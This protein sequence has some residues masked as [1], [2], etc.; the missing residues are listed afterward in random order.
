MRDVLIITPTRSRPDSAVRLADAVARTATAQTDLLF[1]IDEDDRSYDHLDLTGAAGVVRGPRANCV[2]WS[3]RLAA[4]YGHRYRALASL[5]D[6]HV[7]LTSGW[8]STLLAA[9]DGMGGTGISYGNDTRQ[10]Q[11]LPT[12]PV[13]S[14]SIVTELGWFFLPAMEHFFCDNAWKDIASR[15][16]CLRYVP[17]VTILHL[18]HV[19]GTAPHDEVYAAADPA[20]GPDEAEYRR[21]CADPAGLAAD[22]AKVRALRER[23]RG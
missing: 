21:Y 9:I 19:W 15:A 10:G 5:G 14:S 1:A 23:R 12:A 20:Y 17:E 3:N 2:Q 18:H 13:V 7:P 4:R 8:D 16:G 11:N 22:A 6:D